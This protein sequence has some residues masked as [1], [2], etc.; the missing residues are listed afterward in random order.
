MPAPSAK[1]LAR[2]SA[3]ATSAGSPSSAASRRSR[4]SR[5]MVPACNRSS[6][7]GSAARTAGSVV[8][9]SCSPA[10]RASRN[11]G[12]TRSAT[13]SAARRVLSLPQSFGPMSAST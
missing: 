6:H 13:A 7:R 9:L 4:R 12:H 5:P 11:E 3:S 1:A 8:S 10:S 2:S